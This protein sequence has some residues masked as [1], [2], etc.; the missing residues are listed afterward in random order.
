MKKVITNKVFLIL[1]LI[2]VCLGLTIFYL[3]KVLAEIT[4]PK[5][6][7]QQVFLDSS[8]VDLPKELVTTIEKELQEKPEVFFEGE[9]YVL[10]GVREEENWRF[11][12][13]A[14]SIENA[15]EKGAEIPF[16]ETSSLIAKQKEDQSWIVTLQYTQRYA[17]LMKEVPEIYFSQKAKKAELIFP[18]VYRERYQKILNQLPE[19]YL[20]KESEESLY[21][22]QQIDDSIDYKYPWDK[23]NNPWVYTQGWH[24]QY[25]YS[26]CTG[27]W[28]AVDIAT[29][30]TDKSLLASTSGEV[31]SICTIGTVSTNVY[32][33]NDDGVLMRYC[34]IDKNKLEVKKGDTIEQGDLLGTLIT[35]S[36]EFDG[37]G[38]AD[39]NSDTG[40]VHW[41]I[42]IEENGSFT[43]DEWTIDQGDNIWRKGEEEKDIGDDLYSSNDSDIPVDLHLENVNYNSTEYFTATNSIT[44]GPN[45]TIQNPYG[46][47]TFESGNYIRLDPGFSV[48]NGSKFH[49][50]INE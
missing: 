38:S 1:M 27:D 32:V 19:G 48:Q 7:S 13:I 15:Y 43:A 9:K 16:G 20:A 25:G 4:S 14:V 47:V 8:G 46:D 39:Q 17:D 11:I 26:D 44:A 42:P 6:D 12:S 49:A 33:K 23:D 28:C 35:G 22:D 10:T 24:D 34:H 29:N 21:N 37:C 3:P 41:V 31:D 50:K 36:F 2:L 30:N 5:I 45:V 40:H 18:N